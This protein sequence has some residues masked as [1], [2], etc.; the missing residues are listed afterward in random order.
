MNINIASSSTNSTAGG[1]A[2]YATCGAALA[3]GMKC[4]AFVPSKSAS[5]KPL[6]E[7]YGA[8]VHVGG[9]NFQAALKNAK[10]AVANNLDA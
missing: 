8:T 9:E 2:A 1:N 5:V 4:T 6:L 7:V 3:L 10:E